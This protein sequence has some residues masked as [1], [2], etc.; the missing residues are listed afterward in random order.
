[1]IGELALRPV[2]LVANITVKGTFAAAATTC[3]RSRDGTRP[4]LRPRG[5]G[6]MSIYLMA[7]EILNKEFT[8]GTLVQI[9][10]LLNR[11]LSLTLFLL[12]LSMKVPVVKVQH[13]WGVIGLGALGAAQPDF[14]VS[15]LEV[16]EI[17][18]PRQ[19]PVAQRTHFELEKRILLNLRHPYTILQIFIFEDIHFSE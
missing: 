6:R 15:V 8:K 5:R 12:R 10:L 13:F 17:V 3:T 2:S 9:G 16:C 11:L 18:F 1:V 14:S 19:S 7:F 4:G